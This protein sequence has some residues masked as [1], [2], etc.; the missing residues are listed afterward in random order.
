MCSGKQEDRHSKNNFPPH[1]PTLNFL[2]NASASPRGP[3]GCEGTDG[4][5]KFLS[6]AF[7]TQLELA[8]YGTGKPPASSPG[9]HPCSTP[10]TKKFERTPQMLNVF[11]PDDNFKYEV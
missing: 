4:T 3:G 7:W 8:V 10:T 9:G 5:Q 6:A 2:P 11:Q 1:F